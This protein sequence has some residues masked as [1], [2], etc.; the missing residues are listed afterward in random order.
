MEGDASSRQSSTRSQKTKK[1]STTNRGARGAS[2]LVKGRGL[3]PLCP[4]EPWHSVVDDDEELVDGVGVLRPTD[5][6]DH[7]DL[8]DDGAPPS[9]SPFGGRVTSQQGLSFGGGSSAD[10]LAGA[11]PAELGSEAQT[12]ST[13]LGK[14]ASPRFLS[15][16]VGW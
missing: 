2:P 12:F 3:V 5:G 15:L 4:D 1:K 16:R 7:D 9:S 11:S 14:G 8:V 10:H 13:L 6:M